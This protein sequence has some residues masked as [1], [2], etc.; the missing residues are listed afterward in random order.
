M[1]RILYYALLLVLLISV[2]GCVIVA[3]PKKKDEMPEETA[4][5]QAKEEPAKEEETKPFASFQPD[6]PGKPSTESL[7]KDKMLDMPFVEN[8]EEFQNFFY[9]FTSI[10]NLCVHKHRSSV[11]YF[12][13]YTLYL[14]P[15]RRP[16]YTALW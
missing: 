10:W 8:E 12:F 2:M 16:S 13:N 9:D 6:T 4:E 1:K 5:E 7:S 3:K 14:I 11:L 15:S